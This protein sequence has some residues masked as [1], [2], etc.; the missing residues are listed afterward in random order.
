MHCS[1]IGVCQI[2]SNSARNLAEAEFGKNGRISNLPKP[3]FG[4]T[5]VN[6][7]YKPTY[8]TISNFVHCPLKDVYVPTSKVEL[9][10]D[11]QTNYGQSQITV[12]RVHGHETLQLQLPHDHKSLVNV[13][14]TLLLLNKQ[15]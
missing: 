7:E 8:S 6:S 9:F 14:R 15:L 5:L 3:K 10:M 2:R 12:L 11:Y 13:I 1:C 4:A